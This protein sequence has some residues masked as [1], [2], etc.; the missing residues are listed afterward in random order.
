MKKINK[1]TYKIHLVNISVL[2]NLKKID[3]C[4]DY[5]TNIFDLELDQSEIIFFESILEVLNLIKE[6]KN[7]HYKDY[8]NLATIE[9]KLSKI[10]ENIEKLKTFDKIIEKEFIE[11]LINTLFSTKDYKLS[12]FFINWQTLI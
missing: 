6:I 7:Q 4:Q 8:K 9:T 10:N 12:R 11:E 2:I 1:N 3:E 5:I